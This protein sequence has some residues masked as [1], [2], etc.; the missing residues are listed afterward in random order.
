MKTQ[1][2]IYFYYSLT[3]AQGGIT[4]FYIFLLFTCKGSYILLETVKQIK[5]STDQFRFLQS[6]IRSAYLCIYLCIYLCLYLERVPATP[7]GL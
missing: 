7:V 5:T 6:L 1:N 3:K 2:K 4:M